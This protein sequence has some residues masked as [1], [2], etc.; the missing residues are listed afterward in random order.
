MC[1]N[2]CDLK[3]SENVSGFIYIIGIRETFSVCVAMNL[4]LG[5]SGQHN[6]LCPHGGY[7]ICQ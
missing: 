5:Y 3:E 4:V 6:S 2:I 7:E 1:C